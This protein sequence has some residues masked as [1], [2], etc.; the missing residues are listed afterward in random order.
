VTRQPIST[1]GDVVAYLT[2][3]HEAIRALFVETLDAKNADE[4]QA[5]FTR[6]RTLLAVHKR[7]RR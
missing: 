1:P 5:V 3:Q 2:S 7:P 6:L 4:Q